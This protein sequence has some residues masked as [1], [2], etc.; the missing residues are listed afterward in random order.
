[1]KANC[2]NALL[3]TGILFLSAHAFSQEAK[4]SIWDAASTGDIEAIKAHIEA[5]A[6]VDKTDESGYAPIILASLQKH[7]KLVKFLLEMGADADV[8][9]KSTG[10]TLLHHAAR[11]G[12]LGVVRLLLDEY[13]A[14]LESE[15][16]RLD[17]PLV[18]AAQTGRLKVID[19]LIGKGAEVDHVS[20]YKTPLTVAVQ[21]KHF[22]VVKLLIAQGA[23]VNNQTSHGVSPMIRA[24]EIGSLKMVQLLLE[25]GAKVESDS[26][27]YSPLLAAT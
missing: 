13:E 25:S 27:N 2:R 12:D 8:V 21:S 19:Y 3:A 16:K 26:A 15:N 22:S 1:M 11:Y 7:F 5:G 6:D 14:N 17:T 4:I 18:Q 10:D 24:C 23:D 9:Q 20:K